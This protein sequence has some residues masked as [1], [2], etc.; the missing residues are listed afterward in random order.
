MKLG[1]LSFAF[2]IS[3]YTL[4]T[5]AQDAFL[6]FFANI[7]E[8][9]NFTTFWAQAAAQLSNYT[10]VTFLGPNDEASAEI[11]SLSAMTLEVQ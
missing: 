8:L 5:Q 11:L 2:A 1:S 3:T 7:P 10:R 9:S 4:Y 6:D